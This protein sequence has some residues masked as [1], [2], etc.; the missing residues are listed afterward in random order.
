[1]IVIV[2]IKLKI[3]IVIVIFNHFLAMIVIDNHFFDD[4][5]MPCKNFNEKACKQNKYRSIFGIP[6]I[7]FIRWLN[8]SS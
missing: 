2:T 6:N 8:F 4:F 1:M 5:L 3:A 7:Y